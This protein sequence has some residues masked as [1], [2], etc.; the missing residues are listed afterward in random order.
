MISDKM[1]HDIFGCVGVYSQ[2]HSCMLWSDICQ[3]HLS[4]PLAMVK[5]LSQVCRQVS[6]DPRVN[7]PVAAE[8]H[9]H[10][11]VGIYR[12]RRHTYTRRRRAQISGLAHGGRHGW[13]HIMTQWLRC[14]MRKFI[15]QAS[16][17]GDTCTDHTLT[18][19]TVYTKYGVYIY[20][21]IYAVCVCVHDRW[22]TWSIIP[23]TVAHTLDD[24][25]FSI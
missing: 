9:R 18:K 11:L 19:N 20:D 13:I 16:Q 10:V 4:C 24:C 5:L 2:N 21:L 23:T 1:S 15:L 22:Y 7:P 25:I 3:Y 17:K 14:W 8:A 12:R 6:R